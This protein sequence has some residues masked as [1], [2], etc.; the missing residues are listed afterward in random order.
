MVGCGVWVC[1]AVGV[2]C[3]VCCMCCNRVPTVGWILWWSPGQA[4]FFLF[5]ETLTS[6]QMG[7]SLWAEQIQSW[8]WGVCFVQMVLICGFVPDGVLGDTF[9]V[10]ADAS[11]FGLPIS[12]WFW[13]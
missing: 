13:M 1:M 10:C 9:V 7:K 3:G 11:G 2:K 4:Q 12:L 6:Y 8:W 5:F